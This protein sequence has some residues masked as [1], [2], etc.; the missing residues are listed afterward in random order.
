MAT[1]YGPYTPVSGSALSFSTQNVP[2]DHTREDSVLMNPMSPYPP[3]PPPPK[4]DPGYSNLDLDEKRKEYPS[5][6]SIWWQEAGACFLV[7]AM[8]AAVVGTTFPHHDKPLPQ[9]PYNLSINTLVAIYFIILKAAM[10]FVLSE[11]L[12]QLK[13]NWFSEARPLSHLATYD[14]AARGPWGA[15]TFVWQLRGR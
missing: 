13:W 15:F 7:L 2:D 14:D 6:F 12:G 10:L 11:A 5:I 4:F 3:P 9:W 1:T 8:M